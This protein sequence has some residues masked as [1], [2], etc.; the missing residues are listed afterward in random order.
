V[1]P[2]PGGGTV[3]AWPKGLS[4]NRALRILHAIHDFLPRHRA[5]SEIYAFELCRELASRHDVTILCGEYDPVRRHGE[6]AWRVYDG[7]PV[8]ELVNNWQC[9][10]FEETYRPPLIGRRI[11]QLLDAVQPEIVHVHNLTTLSLELPAIARVRGARVVA[12][13]HDYAL[14]CPSG[15]QRLHRADAHLCRDIDTL[16]CARCFR[17]SPYAAQ[18]SF[19]RLAGAAPTMVRRIGS[20]TARRFPRFAAQAARGV[21]RASPVVVTRAGIDERLRFA[22][23]LFEAIDL[24]VAPS[25]SLASEFRRLGLPPDKLRVSDYGSALFEA[26]PRQPTTRLRVGYVGTIA[27]HKGVHVLIE[28]VSRLP[29][30]GWELKVFGSPSVAPDYSAELRARAA[31]LPV[32]F[33]GAFD[34]E[35]LPGILAEID[36]LVVPSLW[37]ENSPLVIHE[38]FIAGVPVVGSRIGGIADL[39]ADGSN[40]IL[41]EP[42]AADQLAAALRRAMDD[43]S[44]P[45]ALARAIPRVKSI[46]QDAREWEAAYRAVL[47][48][49]AEAHAS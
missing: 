16:R 17:E 47:D 15:G 2:I 4:D 23:Q 11:A 45:A 44:L 27:W 22:G 19:G 14:V 38:A 21:T 41:Y 6:V 34:R 46:A 39:V 8:V 35:R 29:R 5:G 30:D 49:R 7:L 31:G 13:L 40:G 36:L 33:M 28:A 18:L 12:T 1:L 20:W 48:R 26:A 10:S 24:F 25:S 32:Q 3:G 42:G 9:D 43:P 37:L